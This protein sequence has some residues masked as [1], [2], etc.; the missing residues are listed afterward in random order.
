MRGIAPVTAPAF[1]G[2]TPRAKRHDPRWIHS[3]AF[4]AKVALV[5]FMGKR[6]PAAVDSPPPGRGF[7]YRLL[8]K[9]SNAWDP[10]YL[11]G[12]PESGRHEVLL[13]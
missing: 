8:R 13:S 10:S 5:A 3:A 12:S 2:L 9:C 1:T 11:I 6:T 4:K 7:T